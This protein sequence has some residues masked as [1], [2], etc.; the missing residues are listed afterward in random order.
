MIVVDA[1]TGYPKQRRDV[2]GSV[3]KNLGE[4]SLRSLDD[5]LNLRVYKNVNRVFAS[6]FFE[7][8]WKDGF[9]QSVFSLA[10]KFVS[11]HSTWTCLALGRNAQ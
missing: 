3:R 7:T 2:E 8:F 5:F 9:V 10:F 11:G 4:I 1:F 6:E